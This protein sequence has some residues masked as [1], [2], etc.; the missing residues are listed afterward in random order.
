MNRNILRLTH[1]LILKRGA[2]ALFSLMERS[3]TYDITIQAFY[4]FSHPVI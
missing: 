4:Q 2:L 3:L 1:F